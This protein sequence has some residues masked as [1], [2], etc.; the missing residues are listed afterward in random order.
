MDNWEVKQIAGVAY[1]ASVL[2]FGGA[3]LI[4]AFIIEK[5]K[6]KGEDTSAC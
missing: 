1:G 6:K 4:V 3:G 5:E 2:F